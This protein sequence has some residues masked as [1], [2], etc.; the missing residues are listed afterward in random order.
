MDDK[1]SNILGTL[2]EIYKVNPFSLGLHT[3][4]QANAESIVKNGLFERSGRT[5]AG[6]VRI[7]GNVKN[8]ATTDDLDWFFHYTDATV[9][10][11]IP[12]FFETGRERESMGGQYHTSEFSVFLDC[13]SSGVLE[14][15]KE[16]NEELGQSTESIFSHGIN[17]KIPPELILG[18]YDREGQLR[19]NEN[20]T[21]LQKDSKFL[22]NI[23]EIYRD[24]HNQSRIDIFKQL[25]K[26][27]LNYGK[28][29][30]NKNDLT[31][32]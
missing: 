1:Y 17:F 25:D 19:L 22:K 9:I 12:S 32:K 30:S 21:M 15:A 18:Y 11:A 10:V 8:D 20:C 3:T 7:F 26:N 4:S 27:K 23:E 6:T 14:C 24:E 29:A 31:I 5:L 28:Y 16:A 13:A 2:N